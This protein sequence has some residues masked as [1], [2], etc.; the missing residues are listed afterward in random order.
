MIG[1]NTVATIQRLEVQK[2]EYGEAIK[3]WVT[4]SQIKGFLDLMSG[5]ASYSFNAKL[6]ESTHVFISDYRTMPVNQENGRL[7]INNN[8]YEITYIDNPMELNAQIEI[9]LKFIGGV[10]NVG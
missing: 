3:Q 10:Q 1:G 9:F 4:I 2:N 8:V 5:N 7:L 6:T